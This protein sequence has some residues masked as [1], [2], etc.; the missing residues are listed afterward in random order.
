MAL[1]SIQNYLLGTRQ[2]LDFV[3]KAL[4]AFQV[5]NSELL[6]TR[7]Q[8]LA[9][10]QDVR[11]QYHQ[12]KEG[13]QNDQLHA[14][15]MT[16]IGLQREYAAQDQSMQLAKF[17][18]DMDQRQWEMQHMAPLE[19]QAMQMDNALRRREYDMMGQEL[20]AA[21]ANDN[22]ISASLG[23]VEGMMT[24]EIPVPDAALFEG[25][26]ES[27][28][29]TR[30][31]LKMLDSVQA[32]AETT[33]NKGALQQVGL[34]RQSLEAQPQYQ[35]LA[36]RPD[37]LALK[38]ELEQR[39]KGRLDAMRTSFGFMDDAEYNSWMQNNAQLHTNLANT[40]DDDLFG[41]ML[42][43]VRRSTE[44]RWNEKRSASGEFQGPPAP[45]PPSVTERT[46]Y[47]DAL[48]NNNDQPFADYFRKAYPSFIQQYAP[49]ASSSADMPSRGSSYI[50]N[51]R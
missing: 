48:Q 13:L 11:D 22:A 46:R 5:V 23:Q 45:E 25:E 4:D 30:A 15:Q 35:E 36:A 27:Y 26:D 20:N 42:S 12:S 40:P 16:D 14:E 50:N 38:P 33:N 49:S 28:A 2:P 47:F 44:K 1:P 41:R 21:I 24:G 32:T 17:G 31:S 9:E 8:N 3:G 34:L 19:L 10:S 51:L 18:M 29:R 6:K 43:D 37:G 39:T 7:Q